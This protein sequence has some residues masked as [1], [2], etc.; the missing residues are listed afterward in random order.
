MKK[1]SKWIAVLSAATMAAGVVAMPASTLQAQAAAKVKTTAAY[2][3]Q[4]T[5]VYATTTLL[6]QALSNTKTNADGIYEQLMMALKYSSI[7]EAGIQQ[8]VSEGIQIPTS[9]LTRLYTE[10]WISGILYKTLTGQTLTAADYSDVFDATYYVNANPA[11]A[12]AVQ[13][14]ALPNDAETLL[15][16]WL[17]CGLPAGLAGNAT[18]SIT[19]FEAQYPTIAASLGNNRQQ[20]VQYY[21]LHKNSLAAAAA[22]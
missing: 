17:L 16:N 13:S 6:K 2:P 19:N 4:W 22:K 15:Q 20:E 10:G 1:F 11:I 5:T 12:A 21:I 9:V 7:D 14:G 18:F 3:T 8:L